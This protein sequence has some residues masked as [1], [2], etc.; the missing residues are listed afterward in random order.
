MRLVAH[1]EN[2][3]GVLAHSIPEWMLFPA[4]LLF[5]SLVAYSGAP[6]SRL[7]A[8]EPVLGQ[9]AVSPKPRASRGSGVPKLQ[10]AS[11]RI[12][13]LD[14][15]N[16][17][18]LGALAGSSMD[19]SVGNRLDYT[20]IYYFDDYASMLT[21]LKAKKIDA[22]IHDEPVARSLVADDPS[23][24]IVPELFEKVDYAFGTNHGDAKLYEAVNKVIRDNLA[25][26]GMDSLIAKW[27][28]GPK[29]G[30]TL[31]A[32]DDAALPPLRLGTYP[33]LEP[34][35]YRDPAGGIVG[36]DIELARQ[37]SANLGRRLVIVPMEFSELIASLNRN[38]V[39]VIGSCII[40]TE[41]RAH[42]VHFTDVYYHGGVAAV[43]RNDDS[44]Q[45]V[46]DGDR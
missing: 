33:D 28:D 44:A 45:S 41:A 29:A 13:S 21:A 6:W 39:D 9:V 20:Q 4:C 15:L 16:K 17:R 8:G 22:I 7:R 43:V 14:D 42:H 23:L 24:R 35:T 12:E 25:G 11:D 30:K 10:F 31:P 37:M 2:R 36:L 27:V 5:L 3:R 26:G 19:I 1:V 38:D 34:F 18:P 46:T 40:V 32:V